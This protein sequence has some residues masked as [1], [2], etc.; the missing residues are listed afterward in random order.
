MRLVKEWI[1]RENISKGIKESL[2]SPK[3]DLIAEKIYEYLEELDV[4]LL[5]MDGYV[6]ERKAL[7]N[8]E[9]DSNDLDKNNRLGKF[10]IDALKAQEVIMDI[11]QKYIELTKMA[12]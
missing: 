12:E 2:E 1:S 4:F 8:G 9:K 6:Q 5:L 10:L 11:C 3:D 7:L